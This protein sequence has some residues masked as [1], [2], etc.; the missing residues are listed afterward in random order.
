MKVLYLAVAFLCLVP[1]YGSADTSTQQQIGMLKQLLPGLHTIT[2]IC[3]VNDVQPILHELKAATASSGIELSV[4]DVKSFPEVY[5]IFRSL[6]PKV[7]L[8]WM[9]QDTVASGDKQGR[10]FLEEN[11][12][13]KK[14]PL[15]AYSEETLHEGALLF[16]SMQNGQPAPLINK[17]V[18]GLIDF[19]VPPGL[20][21]KVT[22]V[23]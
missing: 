18:A 19:H 15:V 10:R 21:S 8:I 9:V 14:I 3:N 12:L 2:V 13:R 7:D 17:N 5:K 20:E 16:L 23:D 4:F 11:C 1:F 22:V 6:P